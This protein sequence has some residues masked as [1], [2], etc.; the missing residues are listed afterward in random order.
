ML[1]YT[2]TKRGKPS[3]KP[4]DKNKHWKNKHVVC[5]PGQ[6]YKETGLCVQAY[7][8]RKG[9][10]T[11]PVQ[12]DGGIKENHQKKGQHINRKHQIVVKINLRV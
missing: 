5:F 9:F 12:R 3:P 4:G 2:C 8:P 7:G 11:E 6:M 1:V 10:C